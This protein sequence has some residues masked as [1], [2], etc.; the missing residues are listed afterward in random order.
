MKG[1]DLSRSREQELEKIYFRY[2]EEN[3]LK[4]FIIFCEKLRQR[5][6]LSSGMDLFV[7]RCEIDLE[8]YDCARRILEDLNE[9]EPTAEGYYWLAQN[10]QC[11]R[12]S[13]KNMIA[14][15]ADQGINY[16][17]RGAEPETHL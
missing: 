11:K 7:A 15:V 10:R 12:S 6:T 13:Q 5:L 8:H 4:A 17:D 16:D 1:L 9:R 14:V 3:L 2:K